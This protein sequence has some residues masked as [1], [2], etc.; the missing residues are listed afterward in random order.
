MCNKLTSLASSND[1]RQIYRCEHGTIHLNWDLITIYLDEATLA[2]ITHA[3][4]K[5]HYLTKPGHIQEGCLSHLLSCERL[6]SALGSE[7]CSQPISD[8][9]LPFLFRCVKQH[10]TSSSKLKL[11]DPILLKM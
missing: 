4:D 7:C 5:S 3:L 6:L 10:N 11:P 9:F 2:Q 8:R 1:Y